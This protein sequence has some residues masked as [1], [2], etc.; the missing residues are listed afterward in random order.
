VAAADKWDEP[1]RFKSV[2]PG[3]PQSYE[4]LL[5]EA[6]LAHY[7]LDLHQQQVAQALRGPMLERAIGVIYRWVGGECG[8]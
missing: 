7:A 4:G 5:H 3:L 1:V 2:N 8:A 6:G